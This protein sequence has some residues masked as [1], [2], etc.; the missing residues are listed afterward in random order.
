LPI[1]NFGKKKDAPL[2]EKPASI[3]DAMVDSTKGVSAE[4]AFKRSPNSSTP[5]NPQ[6][7]PKETASDDDDLFADFP[8]FGE[9]QKKEE[10]Q[11]REEP[12]QQSYQ[13][14]PVNTEPQMPSYPQSS[15]TLD[16]PINFNDEPQSEMFAQ[17]LNEEVPD[18]MSV[19]QNTSVNVKIRGDFSTREIPEA[20]APEQTYKVQNVEFASRQEQVQE[21]VIQPPKETLLNY[22]VKAEKGRLELFIEFHDMRK[23]TDDIDRLSAIEQKSD[24]GFSQIEVVHEHEKKLLLSLRKSLEDMH[25]QFNL[26]DALIFENSE[27]R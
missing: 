6:P 17:N 25:R 24:H 18:L 15:P 20:Q 12:V 16:D 10:P 8:L 4:E 1:F 26:M 5:M 2:D 19:P 9:T 14:P 22:I 27:N 3:N 23:L 7:L 13:A 11:R 21:P